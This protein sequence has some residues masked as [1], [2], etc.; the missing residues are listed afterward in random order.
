MS[1][2][3]LSINCRKCVEANMGTDFKCPEEC[4]EHKQESDLC[5]KVILWLAEYAGRY[6]DL[7][8]EPMNIKEIIKRA[9]RESGGV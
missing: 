2:F 4:F 5:R 9:I 6:F 3:P 8:D 1:T 7:N